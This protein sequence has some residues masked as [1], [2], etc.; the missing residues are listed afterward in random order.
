MS[1]HLE[2]SSSTNALPIIQS[3]VTFLYICDW[4][5]KNRAYLHK[6]Y[7]CLEN[8]TFLGH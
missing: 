8:D 1:F 6:L 5:Y 4:A 3:D 2:Q 7:T